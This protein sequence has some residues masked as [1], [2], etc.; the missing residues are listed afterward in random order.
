MYFERFIS[1]YCVS[2]SRIPQN[3]GP[4]LF[5]VLIIDTGRRVL[6][7]YLLFADDL[8]MHR[9]ILTLSDYKIIQ[10]DLNQLVTWSKMNDLPPLY[11][12]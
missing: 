5:I 8:K 3:L 12:Q 2:S 4:L 10:G 11:L 6:S 7:T 1:E 9:P